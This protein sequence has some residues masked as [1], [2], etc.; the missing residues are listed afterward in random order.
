[1]MNHSSK[2]SK[3]EVSGFKVD[4]G[5]NCGSNRIPYNG[6]DKYQTI[7]VKC[8]GMLW[9]WVGSL[10]TVQMKRFSFLKIAIVTWTGEWLIGERCCS[11]AS[12][13]AAKQA[14]NHS[15]RRR[16]GVKEIKIINMFSSSSSS[17]DRDL[18]L[19]STDRPSQTQSHQI[20]FAFILLV[21]FF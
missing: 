17:F 10:N 5:K 7:K 3:V 11:H 6:C 15:R 13:F 2:R 18:T 12:G 14:D 16:R 19:E 8:M 1:M 4:E 21:V 9:S 20:A